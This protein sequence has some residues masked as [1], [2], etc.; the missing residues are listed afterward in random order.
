M[1][2]V[3]ELSPTQSESPGIEDV[4]REGENIIKEEVQAASALVMDE[5]RLR[6]TRVIQHKL[7]CPTSSS[8]FGNEK[9]LESIFFNKDEF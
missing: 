1:T 5:F 6:K 4:N 7:S 2:V 9:C 3:A 8:C